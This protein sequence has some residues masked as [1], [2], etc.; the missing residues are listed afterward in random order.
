MKSH[1]VLNAQLGVTG[2]IFASALNAQE[3]G[4]EDLGY[5]EFKNSGSSALSTLEKLI[6]INDAEIL[7]KEGWKIISIKSERALWTFA[8]ESYPVPPA[9]V[10]RE[11]VK[12]AIAY[13]ETKATCGASKDN[14][15][16]LVND[17]IELNNCVRENVDQ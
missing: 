10:K 8:P 9:F 13:I 3:N 12:K 1:N 14:C 7:H 15:D 4:D 16:Q 17:F 2:L 11:V 5:K 6:N